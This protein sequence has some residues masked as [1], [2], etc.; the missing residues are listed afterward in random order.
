MAVPAVAPELISVCAIVVPL[1]AEAPETPLW[2]TVQ[3]NVVPETPPVNEIQVAEPEQSVCEAGV[4]ITS[5]TGY[6]LIS[7][8][9]ELQ[10]VADTVYV[11][12]TVPGATAVARPV[13]SI[14]AINALLLLHVPAV[15]GVR[16]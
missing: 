7:G 15:A 11:K 10:P 8:V 6:T 9:V 14:V 1:P 2:T 3:L 13:L 12:V 16:L 5:G 4:A